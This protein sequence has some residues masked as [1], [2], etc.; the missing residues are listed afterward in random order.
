WWTVAIPNPLDLAY[1]PLGVLQVRGV[2]LWAMH[3][4][5]ALN[6]M[7]LV[8][9]LFNLLPIFPLDGGRIV[10]AV[11]WPRCGYSR[12]MRF[13]VY[14]GYLGAIAL[15]IVGWVTETWM[16]VA[17][18]VFG[19]V[20]CYLTVKQ[21]DWTDA[22]MGGGDSLY[23]ASLWGEDDAPDEEEHEV[24]HSPRSAPGMGEADESDDTEALD[25]ILAKIGEHGMDSLSSREKRVLE[26]ATDRRR[27]DET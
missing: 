22:V 25:R 13:A 19:G 23:A 8:L 14:V 1:P 16:L 26:R 24:V 17:I 11:L 18:A 21:L 20:T 3:G 6:S 27:Q 4:L 10:Q 12:S 5:F 2:P 7:N 15:G 9:L